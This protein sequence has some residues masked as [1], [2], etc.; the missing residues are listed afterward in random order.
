M[1][2]TLED[3][4]ISRDAGQSWQRV[5]ENRRRALEDN[6]GGDK[7]KFDWFIGQTAWGWDPARNTLYVA[8][9]KLEKLTLPQIE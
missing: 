5:A 9:G 4:L 8:H 7:F 1:V 6:F 3:V 2:V